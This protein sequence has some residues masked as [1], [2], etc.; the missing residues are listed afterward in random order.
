MRSKKKGNR[1]IAKFNRNPYF[2]WR[3]LK[4]IWNCLNVYLARANDIL[5]WF[6]CRRVYSVHENND[7]IWIK[8]SSVWHMA[9]G[10]NLVF[11]V[12]ARSYQSHLIRFWNT[13]HNRWFSSLQF[14]MCS[15]FIRAVHILEKCTT[16][17]SLTP[18]PLPLPQIFLFWYN[19]TRKTFKTLHRLAIWTFLKNFVKLPRVPP[20]ENFLKFHFLRNFVNLG[21]IE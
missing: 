10:R 11:F 8:L 20:W 3:K 13:I 9:Y 1:K 15:M 6:F 17:Q 16:N 7:E 5:W 21:K 2:D 12:I 19:M 18:L 4:F 14:V